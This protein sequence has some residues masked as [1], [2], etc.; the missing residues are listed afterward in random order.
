MLRTI[1]VTTAERAKA[2]SGDIKWDGNNAYKANREA[3]CMT[4]QDEQV[5]TTVL[6][7]HFALLS[8]RY[9]ACHHERMQ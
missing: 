5:F 6:H 2:L 9:H 1:K 7:L 4:L 8:F 3:F